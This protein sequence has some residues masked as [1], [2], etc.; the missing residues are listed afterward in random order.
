MQRKMDLY[1]HILI[2]SWFYSDNILI[3]EHLIHIT[4][5]CSQCNIYRATGNYGVENVHL[6]YLA[7]WSTCDRKHPSWGKKVNVLKKHILNEKPV[8]TDPGLLQKGTK[9]SMYEG[10]AEA[11][12]L[13]T[14]MVLRFFLST[15]NF[16]FTFYEMVVRDK[17]VSCGLHLVLHKF[18]FLKI[19]MSLASPRMEQ[20]I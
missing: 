9:Q 3:T 11:N 5:W 6:L 15:R 14:G 17:T 1:C 8:A 18:V 12:V 2:I 13:A 20:S 10:G 4:T 19:K 7:G 16:G